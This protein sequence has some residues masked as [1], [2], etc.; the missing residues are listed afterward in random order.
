MSKKITRLL[1]F[2]PFLFTA[3]C[4]GNAILMP[5]AASDL[6]LPAATSTF[7]PDQIPKPEN[8]DI[9]GQEPVDPSLQPVFKACSGKPLDVTIPDDTRL[10]AGEPFVKTW[11]IENSGNCD[12]TEDFSI[13]WFSG[14]KFNALPLKYINQVVHPG[15]TLEISLYMVAP[16]HPG[17]YQSNWKLKAPDG[18]LFGLG[19]NG[20]A[21]FWVKIIVPD[22]LE[23]TIEPTVIPPT[24]TPMV[25]VSDTIKMNLGRFFEIQSGSVEQQELGQIQFEVDPQGEIVL[26]P[27][28]GTSLL[29]YGPNIPH[30]LDCQAALLTSPL[31]LS[32][33]NSYICFKTQ[34]N[35]LG[36]LILRNFDQTAKTVTIEYL[37]WFTP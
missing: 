16:N 14:D 35:V 13:V 20:D 4:G 15:E 10:E 37:A 8:S 5:D 23:S 7:P 34:R 27:I 18:H 32:D 2:I 30:D 17:I 31:T 6:D 36:Y 29:Q 21:P 25:Y 26:I 11:R 24:P 9:T 22:I 28:N 1:I 19:P 12:W 3:G 33:P